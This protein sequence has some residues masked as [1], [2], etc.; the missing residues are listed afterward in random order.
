M[1]AYARYAVRYRYARKACATIERTIVYARYA[2][3]YRYARKACATIER[4]IVY[5]R[6]TARNCYT[7][8][9]FAILERVPAYACYGQAVVCRRNYNILIRACADTRNGKAQLVIIE[10]KLQSFAGVFLGLFLGFFL[11][12]TYWNVPARKILCKFYDVFYVDRSV[13]VDVKR[14]FVYFYVPFCKILCKC[15]KILYGNCSVAVY[16]AC[17]NGGYCFFSV[18]LNIA[19]SLRLRHGFIRHKFAWLRLKE[20]NEIDKS[21][22]FPDQIQ[23]LVVTSYPVLSIIV[24]PLSRP[25]DK[26]EAAIFKTIKLAGSRVGFA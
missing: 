7:C 18:M 11:R 12:N 21:I 14:G 25:F 10:S 19:F 1:T 8:K 9:T 5:A 16:V 3:R 17:H 20:I 22:W 6:Y 2:V 24:I 4:T 26:A 13:A 15:Y 23:I